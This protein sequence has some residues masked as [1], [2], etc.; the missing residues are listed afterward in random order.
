M[1]K[2]RRQELAAEIWSQEH[3]IDYVKLYKKDMRQHND[4][5]QRSY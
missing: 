5:E 2:G 1:S 3:C 4:P